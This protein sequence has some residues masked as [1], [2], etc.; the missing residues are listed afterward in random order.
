M[1]VR[2]GLSCRPVNLPEVEG[3]GIEGVLQVIGLQESENV[4]GTEDGR[5]E[6]MDRVRSEL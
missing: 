5:N 2:G 3:G 6:W 1:H 4:G